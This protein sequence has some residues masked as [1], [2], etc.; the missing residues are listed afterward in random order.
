M[1]EKNTTARQRQWLYGVALAAIA[2][3][4]T[5]KIIDPAHAP[6][7]LDLAV[8][9]IGLG[10]PTAATGTATVVLKEQRKDGTVE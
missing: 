8:N 7:W 9:V 2:L 5:Y 3:L 6:L 1:L 4:V 10:V